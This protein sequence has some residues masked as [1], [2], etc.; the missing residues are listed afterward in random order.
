MS[1]S[2]SKSRA[3]GGALPSALILICASYGLFEAL[4]LELQKKTSQDTANLAPRVARNPLPLQ[5]RS[6]NAMHHPQHSDVKTYIAELVEPAMREMADELEDKSIAVQVINKP[7]DEGARLEVTLGEEM[8][9]EYEVR[10][11]AYLRPTF[12]LGKIPEDAGNKYYRAEVHLR[13]GGQDYNVM[14]WSREQI[15][16]DIPDQYEKNLH[17]LHV[18]R[19]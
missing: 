10:P 7:E 11:R 8:D 13:K 3:C 5:Q 2:Q 14:G 16:A 19:E 9:F 15:L 4:Q 6:H 1:W 17:F 18:V 12:D